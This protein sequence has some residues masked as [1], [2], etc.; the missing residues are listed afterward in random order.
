MSTAATP[1]RERTLSAAQARVRWRMGTE[2]RGLILVMAL[3]LTF[4][5]ALVIEG[6]FQWKWGSSG[7]PYPNPIP[8]G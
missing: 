7:A 5:L 8:G 1:T 2:A 4:G 6:L 3:L